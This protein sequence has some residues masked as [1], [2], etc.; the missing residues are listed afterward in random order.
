MNLTNLFLTMEAQVGGADGFC[1]AT[2]NIWQLVGYVLLV[3]KIVIP[4]LL[5][6]FGMIDLG[7]AVIA[8]KEDEI[9]KATGSLV[10]RAIAA[11]IIF[12]LPTLISFIMTVI[13]GFGSEASED[14]EVC[15]ACITSPGGECKSTADEL[16][17][18]N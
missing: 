9:K 18:N 17:G 12:L 13:G 11:V 4:L 2:A 7:K 5:I 15:K 16:W 1:A 8:S 10:R 6:I 3:F 14:Y